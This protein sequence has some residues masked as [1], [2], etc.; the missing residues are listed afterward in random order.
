VHYPISSSKARI[1]HIYK[2]IA[3]IFFKSLHLSMLV[4]NV[5]GDGYVRRCIF[6]IPESF[7][8]AGNWKKNR[9]VICRNMISIE[10]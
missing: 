6:M 3:P 5:R 8:V 4:W 9:K 7:C 10:K 2:N 1:S